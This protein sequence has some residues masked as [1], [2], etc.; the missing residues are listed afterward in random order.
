MTIGQTDGAIR[1]VFAD[2]GVRGYLHARAVDDSA[3]E[4]SYDAD[5]LVPLASVYKVIVLA[6][7]I[8]AVDSGDIDPR[9]YTTL[10]PRHRT[11]GPSGLAVS[12]MPSRSPG[13]TRSGR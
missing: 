8:R 1:E 2:A 3:D 7:F 10:Q 9:A 5:E 12:V 6:T 13:A 4:V 11:T